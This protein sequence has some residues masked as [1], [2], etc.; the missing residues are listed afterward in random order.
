MPWH[1]PLRVAPG[2]AGDEAS[3]PTLSLIDPKKL[4]HFVVEESFT[5]AVGLEPSTIDHQL[6]NR[7][8]ARSP[9]NL[10]GGTG[11][12]F[13]VNFFVGN[14]VRG[15]KA[16]GGTAIRAPESGIERN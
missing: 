12:G 7:A 11:R 4:G 3:T 14:I 15:Q 13:D 1:A 9:D 2:R 8:L 16:F 6:G 5:W 10:F